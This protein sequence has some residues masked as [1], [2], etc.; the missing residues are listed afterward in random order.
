MTLFIP[1]RMFVPVTQVL[2]MPHGP[3]FVFKLSYSLSLPALPF[4]EFHNHLLTYFDHTT[5]S[6]NVSVKYLTKGQA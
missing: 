2:P 4:I 3:M 1:F 6:K 5:T